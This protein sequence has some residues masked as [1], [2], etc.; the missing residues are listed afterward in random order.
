[1]AT[2][3][4]VPL[5]T[6]RRDAGRRLAARLAPLGPEQP[7]VL[8]VPPC[9][10]PVAFEVAIALGA[11]LDVAVVRRLGVPFQPELAMGAV[12]E[13]GVTVL[14]RQVIHITGVSEVDLADVI[15]RER[16]ELGRYAARYRQ[17]RERVPLEGRTVVVVDDGIDSGST[18]RATCR[19][20]RSA[21]AAR[22]ILAVPV[23]PAGAVARLRGEV[24]EIVSL[25][26][27]ADFQGVG[28]FYANF[29]HTG[30]DEV[31]ACLQQAAGRPANHP[32]GCSEPDPLARD[33]EVTIAVGSLRLPGHLTVP[34]GATGIV[35]FAHGSGSSRHSPRN[36]F[37][38]T[39]LNRA[40]VGTLLFDLLTPAEEM[41]HASVFDIGLLADRLIDATA[42][43][44][45]QSGEEID[46][47]GYLGA[48]TGAAAAL[49]A[50]AQGGPEIAAVVSRGGRPDLAG[51]Y[52][53]AVRAPTLL[54]VGGRD[55]LVEHLNRA[56]RAALRCENRLAVV[57]G[58]SHL[59]EEPGTLLAATGL[60]RDWF[61]A[62]F[63]PTATAAAG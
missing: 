25:E 13:G 52:L 14:D 2:V 23:A 38:A 8:G 1:M 39:V 16:A 29:T 21:G 45:S 61:L 58:A 31:I 42:W 55:R 43:L 37:A 11:P 33:E 49:R 53:S 22:V 27:P 18:A 50:A 17:V 28:Q 19:V 35:V 5:F 15:H 9:G 57:P 32:E 26:L 51:P 10:V 56:A 20:A 54:I 34:L 30:E 60:A 12:G 63:S 44:R 48:S 41:E 4:V 46:R 47:I 24:D 3:D 40:G 59:F 6:D 36:R 7:V 62:H